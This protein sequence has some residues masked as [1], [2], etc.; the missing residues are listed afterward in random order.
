VLSIWCALR[1]LPPALLDP[2]RPPLRCRCDL[3]RVSLLRS[4]SS[5]FFCC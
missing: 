4:G 3:F 5:F 1:P 2:T